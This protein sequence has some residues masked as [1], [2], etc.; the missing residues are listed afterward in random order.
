MAKDWFWFL[1]NLLKDWGCSKP[2]SYTISFT[3]NSVVDNFSF[4]F[5]ITL[6]YVLLCILS[7]Q[8]TQHQAPHRTKPNVV[9]S[10]FHLAYAINSQTF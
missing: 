3:D 8:G 7:G 9:R 6:L 5:S 1:N 4:A 2:N 10:Y